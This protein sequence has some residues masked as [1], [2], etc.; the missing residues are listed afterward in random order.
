MTLRLGW[1]RELSRPAA[2]YYLLHLRTA[3][4][5]TI[6][7]LVLIEANSEVVISRRTRDPMRYRDRVNKEELESEL[8]L[9]RSFLT[10]ASSISGAPMMM[11]RNEEGRV[12][13]TVQ[14][15]IDVLRE[16]RP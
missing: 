14:R 16:A 15:L 13:E 4:V 6:Y 1:F 12:E 5:A 3:L 11:L 2:L 8:L 7:H 10:T 9:A